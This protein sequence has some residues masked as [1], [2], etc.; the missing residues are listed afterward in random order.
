MAG[1]REHGIDPSGKTLGELRPAI[2]E[3][4][5]DR[6]T[7]DHV[8]AVLLNPERNTNVRAPTKYL[9]TGLVH[10]GTCGS[11]MSARPRDDH[12]KRYLCAGNA[13]ATSW[14]SS[15]SRS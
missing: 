2:W 6:Q 15:P 11:R 5:L 13:P 1:L 8:R 3:A 10:C 9:L 12:T 7:W 4:G 14:R